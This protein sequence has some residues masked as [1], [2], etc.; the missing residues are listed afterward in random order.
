[1]KRRGASL[2]VIT[3]TLAAVVFTACG[4][5]PPRYQDERII[6]RLD[7]E[8]TEAGYAIDG[9]LFCEV[10]KKLLNDAD[11]VEAVADKDQLGLVIASR[12]GNVGVLGMPPFAPD[13]ADEAKKKLDKLDPAEE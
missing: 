6:D 3:A 1:M 13:C 7:L 8:K 11:E 12:Q 10:D 5:D 9:D 2:A 4:T